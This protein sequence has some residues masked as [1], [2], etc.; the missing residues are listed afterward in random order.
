MKTIAILLTVLLLASTACTTQEEQMHKE[1]VA[2][3]QERLCFT[4]ALFAGEVALNKNVLNLPELFNTVEESPALTRLVIEAYNTTEKPIEFA[5]ITY[6]K[7][8][9]ENN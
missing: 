3:A 4:E 1:R 8:M 9:K 2:D 5:L 6:K 7:C